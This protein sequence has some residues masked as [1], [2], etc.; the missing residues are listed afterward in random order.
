MWMEHHRTGDK[1]FLQHLQHFNGN[2]ME[3]TGH[4][5][6]LG[7]LQMVPVL[8]GCWST[9]SSELDIMDDT[10][11]DKSF[12]SISMVMEDTGQ[13]QATGGLVVP[14]FDRFCLV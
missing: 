4:H 8:D 10:S 3:D 2:G 5:Q 6:A 12:Y 9:D 11:Q 1:S 7:G 13:H 14:S